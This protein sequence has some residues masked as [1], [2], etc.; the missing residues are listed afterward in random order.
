MGIELGGTDTRVEERPPAPPPDRPGQPGSPSR[1]ES[2][3]AAREAQEARASAAEGRAVPPTVREQRPD[4]PAEAVRYPEVID[5]T[6]YVF[7]EREYAFAGVS[8]AQAS[9]MRARRVPLGIERDQWNACVAELNE[10]LAADGITE[11]DVRL[12]G[13]G[14]GFC[15][16][17]PEKWFP[18]NEG[19]LRERVLHRYRNAP[20]DERAQ[21]AD[22]AV[23]VYREAGF[24]QE[25][26]KPAAP[27]FDSMYKLDAGDG[28][29][30]YDF[31]IASDG[32]ARRFQELEKAAP[33]VEWRSRHGG[34]FKHRHLERVAPAL[35]AWAERWEN[36]FDREV[37]L[38]TFDGR[39]PA[40]GLQ[41][42]DWIIRRNGGSR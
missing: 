26:P 14:A 37:T 16:E 23:A 19:E 36:A 17:N 24:S 6:G 34:H 1:L 15:S 42:D 18:Q 33:D 31:Q 7:T 5:R 20:E 38:A 28:A 25:G 39:G 2:L 3:R 13:S 29:S 32:L 12:K 9:D 22:D 21:R 35:H 4:A 30:D 40:T 27:F 41:D 11:A 10:A 8:P